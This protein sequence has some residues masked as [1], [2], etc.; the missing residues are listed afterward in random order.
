M[1]LEIV[2]Q[3]LEAERA[4]IAAWH[5][6]IPGRIIGDEADVAVLTQIKTHELWLQNDQKQ[7]LA[8]I[9]A[10]LARIAAQRYGVCERCGDSITAERLEAMPLVT[11]CVVCQA[12]LEKKRK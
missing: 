1:N 12:K 8:Q 5:I 6:S 11:L 4:Q 2:R 3:H 10:A 9:D 7:R